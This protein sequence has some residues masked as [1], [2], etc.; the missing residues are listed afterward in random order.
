TITVK[1]TAGEW[2]ALR[3]VGG[4]AFRTFYDDIKRIYQGFD[5]PEDARNLFGLISVIDQP[6]RHGAHIEI[7]KEPNHV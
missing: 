7:I 1:L 2:E 6:T 5:L 4:P 3:I